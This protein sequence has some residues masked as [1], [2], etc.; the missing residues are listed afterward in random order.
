MYK[1]NRFKILKMFSMCA[2]LIGLFLTPVVLVQRTQP[3]TQVEQDQL[4]GRLEKLSKRIAQLGQVLRGFKRDPLRT[5]D[6]EGFGRMA[7]ALDAY[8][9]NLRMTISQGDI[10][11]EPVLREAAE[12]M[13]ALE[14]TLFRATSGL[15]PE[16]LEKGLEILRSSAVQWDKVWSGSQGV[17]KFDMLKLTI[18]LFQE[19]LDRLL[20]KVF[21]RGLTFSAESL[22]VPGEITFVGQSGSGTLGL[23]MPLRVGREILKT[24]QFQ[25]RWRARIEPAPEGDI[26]PLR[27]TDLRVLLPSIDLLGTAT[28]T[29]FVLL[30]PNYPSYGT[31]NLRNGEMR[32]L[33]EVFLFNDLFPP[34]K[35]TLV[36]LEVQGRMDFDRNMLTL[37]FEGLGFVRWVPWVQEALGI[38]K[39][40]FPQAMCQAD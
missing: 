16:G 28:G 8:A 39:K 15:S 23:E 1:R 33:V 4:A 36:S 37:D 25:A 38:E 40:D 11:E 9:A 34:C 24:S 6:A 13:M 18:R 10:I 29:N 26:A 17:S 21:G 12:R 5:E 31:L 2:A 19:K 20:V 30:E 14:Y 35:S 27:I 7:H 22:E 3:G 32:A